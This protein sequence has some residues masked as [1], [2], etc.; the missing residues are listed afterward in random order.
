MEPIKHL[1][2]IDIALHAERLDQQ[3]KYDRVV[4]QIRG[5]T[6]DL[7]KDY[8]NKKIHEGAIKQLDQSIKT[9]EDKLAKIKLGDWSMIKEDKPDTNKSRPEKNCPEEDCVDG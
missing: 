2:L 9:K 7:N 8:T 1:H 6:S 5:I 4:K 3:D